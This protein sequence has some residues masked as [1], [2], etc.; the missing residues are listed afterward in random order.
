MNNINKGKQCK[1]CFFAT[2]LGQCLYYHKYTVL[3]APACKFFVPMFINEKNN[4]DVKK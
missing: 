2:Y 1:D 3:D 4:T